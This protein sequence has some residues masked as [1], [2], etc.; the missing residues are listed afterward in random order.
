M[1]VFAEIREI[2]VWKLIRLWIAEGFIKKVKHKNLEDV[3]EENLRELVDRS[4]VLVGKHCSLGKIK[5]C[6]MHDLVRDMCLREA[7]NENFTHF[8]TRYEHD[9]L[10]GN[11][12][13]LRR[14]VVFNSHRQLDYRYPS[15]L[16]ILMPLARSVFFKHPYNSCFPP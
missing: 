8:K 1:G 7:Q 16:P 13:C 4:L 2:P 3:A 5:T 11:V 10:L 6:K 12:S 14:V 15:E 9:N